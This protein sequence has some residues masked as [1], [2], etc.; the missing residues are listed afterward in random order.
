MENWWST[1]WTLWS[2]LGNKFLGVKKLKNTYFCCALEVKNVLS[3]K[4]VFKKVPMMTQTFHQ[5]LSVSQDRKQSSYSDSLKSSLIC[6]QHG[7]VICIENSVQH[8]MIPALGV[9]NTNTRLS[10]LQNQFGVPP[11]V[12]MK[13]CIWLYELYSYQTTSRIFVLLQQLL[14][15]WFCCL[16]M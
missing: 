5:E 15:Q 13:H 4:N 11:L 12:H 1:L 8:P 7:R 10:G 2:L 14:R 9:C 6:E 3:V 16:Q